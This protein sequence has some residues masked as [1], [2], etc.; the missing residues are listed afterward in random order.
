MVFRVMRLYW[1]MAKGL[2]AS[3]DTYQDWRNAIQQ[4]DLLMPWQAPALPL[5]LHR[6]VCLLFSCAPVGRTA[7]NILHTCA[8]LSCMA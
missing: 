6:C 1:L 5:P 3:R 7:G 4:H 8:Q 2:K